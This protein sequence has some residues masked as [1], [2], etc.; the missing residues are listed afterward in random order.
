MTKI[1]FFIV[2]CI[3]MQKD[4]MGV[5]RDRLGIVDHLQIEPKTLAMITKIKV[6]RE[7]TDRT[8]IS[9]EGNVGFRFWKKM[10]R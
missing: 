5:E 8:E 6:K 10:I 4:G 3:P 2:P 7:R 9:R 1:I